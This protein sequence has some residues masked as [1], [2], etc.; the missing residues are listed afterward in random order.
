MREEKEQQQQQILNMFYPH[1]I[2]VISHLIKELFPQNTKIELLTA[3]SALL[4]I[5]LNDMHH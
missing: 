2:L 5:Q 3:I 4:S 1:V